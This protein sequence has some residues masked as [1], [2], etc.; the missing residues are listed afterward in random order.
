MSDRAATSPHVRSR[1][2]DAAKDKEAV[3]RIWR[4][5]G[6]IDKDRQEQ[7]IDLF[8]GCSRGLVADAN[9]EAESVVATVP[10]T[11][12]YL[13]EDLPLSAVTGLATG[14]IARKRGLAKILLAEA[15]SEDAADGVLLSALWAFEQ[16]FY[17]HLGYGSGGYEHSVAF[18]PCDLKIRRD[19]RMPRRITSSDWELV[20]AS[21]L[22]RMRG[23]GSCSL[24]PSDTTRADMLWPSN[25]FGLGYCEGVTG[26]L[27]HHLWFEAR[28]MDHGP[29]CVVWATYRTTDQLLDLLALIKSFG[30]QV[31]LVEMREPQGIQFQDFLKRPFRWRRISEKSKFENSMHASAWWQVR[32][33]DLFGC[34]E[35]TFLKGQEVRFN[36]QLSDPIDRFL[37][38]GSPWRGLA[39]DYVVSL[40]PSSGSE[41]GMDPGLPTLAASVGAFTRMW[42]GVRPATGL[43]VTDQLSGS[44]ELLEELDWV[45]RLPDPSPDW[46]F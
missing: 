37:G 27:T 40:G 43:A 2:Y 15:L 1:A 31:H 46:V 45:L 4:E 39:G 19:L 23:H 12:R 35:R 25:G 44:A 28:E 11:L 14:R 9:G 13:N 5:A 7:A 24:C 38:D 32:M 21:R 34:L 41:P 29:F 16:G 30:D 10:G 42:L 6:W 17:D 8:L 36:L 20:H 22:V 33:C 18:D 3:H 26:E